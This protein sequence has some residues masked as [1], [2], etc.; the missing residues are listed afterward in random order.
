MIQ[1]PQRD[2]KGLDDCLLDGLEFC[3]RVYELFDQVKSEPEGIEKLRLRPTNRE[4]K[5]LEELLPIANYIQARYFAANRIKIRWINGSQQYDAILWSPLMM[6]RNAGVPRKLFLEVTTSAH[7]NDYLARRLLHEDGGSFGAKSI[8]RDRT[9]RK[10]VSTPYVIV[11]DEGIDDLARQIASRLTE[12]GQKNYPCNTVLIIN[13]IADGVVLDSEWNDAIARVKAMNLHNSFRE[14]FLIEHVGRHCAT[15]Y[16][17]RKRHRR[18]L[19]N[20]RGPSARAS[21]ANIILS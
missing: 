2:L 6:V 11:N 8:H 9:T 10:P 7:K 12:K 16:G 19:A 4:K 21:R 20:I 13:C 5:L 15:L 3:K 18:A 1:S 14:V 17:D